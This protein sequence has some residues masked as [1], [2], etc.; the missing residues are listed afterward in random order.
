MKNEHQIIRMF[1]QNY[2][3]DTVSAYGRSTGEGSGLAHGSHLGALSPSTPGQDRTV[4]GVIFDGHD[5][6]A[7][8]PFACC[9]CCG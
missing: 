7:R 4:C 3:K 1:L 8:V 6:G 5:S 9:E 2:P